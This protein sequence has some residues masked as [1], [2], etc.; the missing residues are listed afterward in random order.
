VTCWMILI[1]IN[2]TLRS[3][4][5]CQ[6]LSSW[7]DFGEVC[8]SC[9][10]SARSRCLVLKLLKFSLCH[11]LNETFKYDDLEALGCLSSNIVILKL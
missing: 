6:M 1:L 10:K 11:V 7:W 8:T 9:V 4:I 5:V 3:E 2:L